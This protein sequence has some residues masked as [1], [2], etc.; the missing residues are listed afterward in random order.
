MLLPKV[1][2]NCI[3]Q[4]RKE[5]NKVMKRRGERLLQ[6]IEYDVPKII[7]TNEIELLRQPFY[8]FFIK[9]YKNKFFN[10]IKYSQILF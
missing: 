3:K 4:T 10:K 1:I 5:Y 6:F 9:K 7:I 8:K 2:K